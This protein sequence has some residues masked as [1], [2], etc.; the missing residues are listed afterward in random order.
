MSN[1][2]S[3]I[4]LLKNDT[5]FQQRLAAKV[6]ETKEIKTKILSSAQTYSQKYE[7]EIEEGDKLKRNL[8]TEGRSKGLDDDQILSS[9]GRFV[10]ARST[11]VLNWLYFLLQESENDN[12]Y[13]NR[14]YKQRDILNNYLTS[15][16]KSED[17]IIENDAT[18]RQTLND[19][20]EETH[21]STR[22]EVNQRMRENT[23]VDNIGRTT[24][25]ELETLIYENVNLDTFNK[26]K[27]LKALAQS[28]NI[29]EACAAHRKALE[30]C[31]EYSLEY[32]RIPC[33]VEKT[34]IK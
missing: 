20:Y 1:N 15:T 16:Y 25:P 14:L 29:E 4:N 6:I 23:T 7:K 28:D 5:N 11:P 9:Y 31:K 22:A 27:K 26:I 3:L 12:I 21:N 17:D 33:Y 32:S 30:M 18:L 13:G 10:P 19:I 2:M 34:N 8:L 24:E